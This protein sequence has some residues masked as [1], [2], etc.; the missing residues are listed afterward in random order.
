MGRWKNRVSRNSITK[1]TQIT[2]LFI[3]RKKDALEGYIY[4]Y[5][6]WRGEA[7]LWLYNTWY[8]VVYYITVSFTYICIHVRMVVTIRARLRYLY[9]KKPL[10]VW[11]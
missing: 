9:K 2:V 8:K 11:L 3:A 6:M 5:V 1:C 10:E 7:I 4:I